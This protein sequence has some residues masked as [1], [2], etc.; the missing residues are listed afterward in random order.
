MVLSVVPVVSAPALVA[1][2][3]VALEYVRDYL[4]RRAI[5]E[6]RVGDVRRQ[7]NGDVWLS[8]GEA[9]PK[10]PVVVVIPRDMVPAHAGYA[11]YQGK[12]VRVNGM[13]RPGAID[14]DPMPEGLA[15]ARSRRQQTTPTKPS[16]L[17]DNP[18]RLELVTLPP[19]P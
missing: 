3:A 7:A 9:Y 2:E 6:A 8:L 12:V 13:V 10:G 5:V 4:N 17:L 16:I 18:Q 11:T 14:E 1:Q 19:E 15:P